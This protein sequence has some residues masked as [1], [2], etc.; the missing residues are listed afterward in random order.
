MP[1]YPVPGL[2]PYFQ[3]R[4]CAQFCANTQHNS[5]T[6]LQKFTSNKT[7][8]FYDEAQLVDRIVSILLEKYQFRVA[9]DFPFVVWP[10]GG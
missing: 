5:I 1:R 7:I 8:L 2:Y 3:G 9:A 6:L 4:A 10:K